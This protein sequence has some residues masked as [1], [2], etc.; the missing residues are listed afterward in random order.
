MK[1]LLL[2][3]AIFFISITGLFAGEGKYFSRLI[4]EGDA[5]ID[6]HINGSKYIKILDFRQSNVVEVGPGE[7]TVAGI[8]AYQGAAGT[9]G[10]AVANAGQLDKEVVLA[11]PIVMY[12]PPLA[13]TTLF[14]SY[15]IGNN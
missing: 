10:M 9:P 13:G 1:K 8:Y 12:V 5:P 3:L 7:F 6:L 11:G 2:P 14:I 4:H 15:F